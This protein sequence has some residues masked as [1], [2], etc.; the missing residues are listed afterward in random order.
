MWSYIE[1][2]RKVCEK[3]CVVSDKWWMLTGVLTWKKGPIY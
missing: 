3:Q 2:E 1:G